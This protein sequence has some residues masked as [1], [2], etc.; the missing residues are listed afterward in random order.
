M[1]EG[2]RRVWALDVDGCLIDSL[3]GTSLRPGTLELLAELRRRGCTVV[4]WSAGGAGYARDQAAA[5]GFVHLVDEFHDKAERDALGRYL[6]DRFAPDLTAVVFV[7]DRPEDMP[8]GAEV[9]AV[10]PYLADNPHDRALAG[11]L[12]ATPSPPPRR[13][14]SSSPRSW[15]RRCAGSPPSSTSSGGPPATSSCTASRC[16]ATP[17][18]PS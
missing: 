6:A 8:T 7:D 18:S 3:T 11:V 1:P 4:V 17:G 5:H 13:T 15:R 16:P 12:A 2:D 10:F 9:V 14:R